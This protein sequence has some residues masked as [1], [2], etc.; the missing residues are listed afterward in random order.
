[1]NFVNQIKMGDKLLVIR[2]SGLAVGFA[3]K[4]PIVK[5]AQKHK[6]IKVFQ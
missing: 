2:G 1:M 3:V 6:E 4:G 5:V